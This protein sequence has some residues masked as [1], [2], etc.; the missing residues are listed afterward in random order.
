METSKEFEH[1]DY[2]I[3]SERAS[4]PNNERTYSIALGMDGAFDYVE[5][6]NHNTSKH[7]DD[8]MSLIIMD[9]MGQQA[10]FIYDRDMQ[11]KDQ[12]SRVDLAHNLA[13]G[14]VEERRK[15]ER[16]N[17]TDALTG[18]ANKAAFDKAK[19]TANDDPSVKFLQLD[20]RDFKK[21][22][23]KHGQEQGD[24]EL[25]NV[26]SHIKQ[27][28]EKLGYGERVFR[29][30]GDE[31]VVLCNNDV[32]EFLL[33]HLGKYQ[34]NNEGRVKTSL[35]G[36]IGDTYTESS[37]LMVGHKEDEH[38]GRIYRLFG[39]LPLRGHQRNAA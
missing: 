38:R 31:F 32:A 10:A 20:L 11:A 26:G 29:I 14:I 28:A 1:I 13:P 22:N 33:Y 35:R 19:D 9:V 27:E 24:K 25:Q 8:E 34:S 3:E 16:E 12:G 21:F 39:S 36:V 30:G 6:I 17:L 18:T 23:D 7:I 37:Q 15:L 5:N 2:E 4:F